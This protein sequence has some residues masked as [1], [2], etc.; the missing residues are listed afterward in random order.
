MSRNIST[1]NNSVSASPSFVLDEYHH[2]P[3][4]APGLKKDQLKEWEPFKVR[5]T[6]RSLTRPSC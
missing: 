2:V 4:T 5:R 6:T 3:V 1:A